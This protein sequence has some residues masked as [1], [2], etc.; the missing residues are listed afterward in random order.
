M[1]LDLISPRCRAALIVLVLAGLTACVTPPALL[2]DE[3]E[4]GAP[5]PLEVSPPTL[6][7][8]PPRPP[9]AP[10]V[11]RHGPRNKKWVALTFDACSTQGHGIFDEKVIRTLIKLDVPATLFLGGKWMEE[12][13]D[14]TQELATYKQFEL[15]NHTY[16]HPHLVR[17]SDARVRDEIQLTQDMLFTLTGRSARLFRA[18]YGE[19]DARVAGLVGELGLISVQYDLA[20]GDPDP[21]ISSKRLAEYVA[22]RS[23]NGSI[24]VLHMNGRGWQT[25]AALPRIVQRLRKD[26]YKFKTVSQLLAITEKTP[27]ANIPAPVA[28]PPAP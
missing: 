5:L 9:E 22:D 28:V 15:A 27:V 7:S 3:R 25:A 14:E 12:H 18:P 21:K 4:I 24:V 8:A 13:P 10:R 20:S 11:I 17:E 2:Q 26:G 6:T 16:R 19:I 1:N 23:K